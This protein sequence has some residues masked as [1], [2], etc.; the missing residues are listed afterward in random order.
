M[1]RD[2]VINR[3]VLNAETVA[4]ES[5]LRAEELEL[6]PGAVEAMQRLQAAGFLLL[7]VSNQ[8]NYA[9]GKA[10]LD[11]LDAIHERLLEQ[12]EQANIDIAEFYYCLHH[13][14]GIVA[15]YSGACECRKPSPY[16]LLKAKA[17]FDL[18][19]DRSWMVGDRESDIQCGQSAGV[20]TIRIVNHAEGNVHEP[21]AGSSGLTASNLAEAATIILDRNA[22][23]FRSI[24]N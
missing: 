17:E 15:D 6:V 13:P 10:T 2:G 9:K 24:R 19:M 16:F 21:L 7:V 11:T 4:W 1:D 8:P 22:Q 23:F 5:P 18:D 14:Q 12:L 20:R 3:N